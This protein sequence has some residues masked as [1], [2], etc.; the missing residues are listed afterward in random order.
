MTIENRHAAD[1]FVIQKKH[2]VS[3]QE[4]Q[5]LPGYSGNG[6]GFLRNA[7]HINGKPIG[8]HSGC[9]EHQKLGRPLQNAAA[10][11]IEKRL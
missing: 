1:R 4:E 10:Q 7:K 2:Y 8:K 9:I 3:R 6:K 5:P 11:R